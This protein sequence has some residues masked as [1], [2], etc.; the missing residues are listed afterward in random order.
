MDP[1]QEGHFHGLISSG[2]QCAASTVAAALVVLYEHSLGGCERAPCLELSHPHRRLHSHHSAL[3]CV[4]SN[5]CICTEEHPFIPCSPC[6]QY[7]VLDHQS[8]SS[9]CVPRH[10]VLVLATAQGAVGSQGWG[11]EAHRSKLSLSWTSRWTGVSAAAEAQQEV[12][13]L[14]LGWFALWGGEW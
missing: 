9:K 10:T 13:L 8:V 14:G 6:L 3:L 1:L 7:C 2:P 12:W 5:K 4:D 11:W